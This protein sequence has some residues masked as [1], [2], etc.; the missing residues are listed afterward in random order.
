MVSCLIPIL[1]L[2]SVLSDSHSLPAVQCPVTAGTF[3]AA[4]L[5]RLQ[6]RLLSNRLRPVHLAPST[7]RTLKRYPQCVLAQWRGARLGK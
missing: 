3:T 4:R 2:F 1:C 6:L 5:P 7:P